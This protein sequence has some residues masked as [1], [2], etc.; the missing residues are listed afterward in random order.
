MTPRAI[1]IHT[2]GV[3]GDTTVAAIRKYHVE[4]NGW[5]DVGYHYLVRKDG[6]VEAGRPLSQLGA[7]T[8]G[9]NDTIGV[10]VAGDGDSEHWTGRQW[11][12]VV[13]LVRAL[14]SQFRSLAPLPVYGHREA[15][16]ALGAAP[17]T[18]TCPGRLV[19]MNDVRAAVEWHGPQP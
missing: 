9:A 15:P 11:L 16:A 18:K 10:C 1:V 8:Q 12:A 6:R 2:V 3:P 7:H 5:R 19:D 14:R 17:T 4:H 13:D